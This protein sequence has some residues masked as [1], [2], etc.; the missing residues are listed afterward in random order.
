MKILVILF[1]LFFSSLAQAAKITVPIDVGVGPSVLNWTGDLATD[2][3]W[4]YGVSI[5]AAA[6]IDKKTL[7]KHKK[8]IPKQYR[9][10]LKKMDEIRIG[11]ALIPDTLILSPKTVNTGMYGATW[12]PLGLGMPVDMGNARFRLGVDALLTYAYIDSDLDSLGTTH[13]LRLGL[14]PEAGLEIPL[15][16]TFLVSFHWRSA[17]YIPQGVG[18]GVANP[19]P[20]LDGNPD[21]SIW[22]VG[23]GSFQLHYRFP[24]STRI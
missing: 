20:I 11:Y 23:Q 2:Q 6:I 15:G 5:S 13:F 8:K 14:G 12:S 7:K 21:G 1:A 16:E 22:H 18:A 4:H 3:Q 24:Y 9:S 10:Q 17:L 19:G